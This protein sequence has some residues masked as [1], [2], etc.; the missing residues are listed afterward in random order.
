MK[1]IGTPIRHGDMMFFRLD[2]GEVAKFSES[3]AQKNLTVGLG[4]VTGHA[5]N[6]KPLKGGQIVEYADSF[7]NAGTQDFLERDQ[8]VFEVKDKPAIVHH[9]EHDTLTLEPGA[10]VRIH[11]QVYDPFAK[12][13]RRVID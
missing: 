7:S 6:V 2:A 9:E 10:Y 3:K 4:E 8:I 1:T 13:I 12:Q 5:H 11:Q